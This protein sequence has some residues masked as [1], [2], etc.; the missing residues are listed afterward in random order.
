M[1]KWTKLLKSATYIQQFNERRYSGLSDGL[2]PAVTSAVLTLQEVLRTG[3]LPKPSQAKSSN[4]LGFQL[5]Q[6]GALLPWAELVLAG[7]SLHHTSYPH[8]V[9]Q[10][11]E[12]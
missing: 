5:R 8:Y 1:K 9:T 3:S 11:A 10:R 6:S 2:T 7:H 12:T 4:H